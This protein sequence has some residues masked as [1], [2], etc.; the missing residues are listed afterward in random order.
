MIQYVGDLDSQT[1][2]DSSSTITYTVEEL[3]PFTEY[4]F[5]VA[6]VNSVGTGPFSEQ[7]LTIKTPESSEFSLILTRNMHIIISYNI[8]FHFTAPGVVINSYP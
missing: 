5:T 4:S 3:I 1:I 7:P 2:T 8:V 6:A